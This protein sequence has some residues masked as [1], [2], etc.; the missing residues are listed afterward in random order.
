[1]GPMTFDGIRDLIAAQLESDPRLAG[2]ESERNSEETGWRINRELVV[3]SAAGSTG[4][5]VEYI[6]NGRLV[7]K[8]TFAASPM[9][10]ERIVHT[11]AEHLTEYAYHR[12]GAR[13]SS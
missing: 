13:P 1:M 10:V 6:T 8:R 11:I 9:I 5:L 12:T 3:I 4:I 7:H 2:L